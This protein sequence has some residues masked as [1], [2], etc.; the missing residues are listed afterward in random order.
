MYWVISRCSVR[1]NNIRNNSQLS[2][3]GLYVTIT[4]FT[5][6]KNPCK[7]LLL[8]L[9]VIMRRIIRHVY[10]VSDAPVPENINGN[11]YFVNNNFQI[12]NLR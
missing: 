2:E 4:C 8:L 1:N 9:N 3:L 7:S 11:M 6:M 12:E 5:Y 10:T